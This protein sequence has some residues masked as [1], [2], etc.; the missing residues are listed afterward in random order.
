MAIRS[1]ALFSH[2]DPF[3]ATI[4]PF[5]HFSLSPRTCRFSGSVAN[6]RTILT[7]ALDDHHDGDR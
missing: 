2:S 1:V 6:R 5:P 3:S 7:L 4:F